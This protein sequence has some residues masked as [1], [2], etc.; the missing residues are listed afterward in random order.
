MKTCIVIDPEAPIL[1][2]I[3]L[4]EAGSVV[5]W[6]ANGGNF[7]EQIVALAP[8]LV[9][10]DLRRCG[11]RC[12]DY[13]VRV[14]RCAPAAK[15]LVLGPPDDLDTAVTALRTGVAGY[16]THPE[17]LGRALRSLGSGDMFITQTG[18][19]ALRRHQLGPHQ[20]GAE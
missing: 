18:W 8:G 3:P 9:V 15:I 11:N 6:V 12:G 2:V 19:A 14:R 20:A 13:V 7:E 4:D 10:L 16:I 17:N 1:P 5:G